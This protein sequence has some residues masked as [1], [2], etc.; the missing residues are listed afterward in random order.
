MSMVGAA[1]DVI[2]P[3]GQAHR[4]EGLLVYMFYISYLLMPHGHLFS[5]FSLTLDTLRYLVLSPP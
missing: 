5:L 3:R 4:L 2:S 1:V